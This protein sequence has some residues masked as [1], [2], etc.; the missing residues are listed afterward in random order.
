M[1][2]EDNGKNIHYNF[3]HW[4]KKSS[5]IYFLVRVEFEDIKNLISVAIFEGSFP[6]RTFFIILGSLIKMFVLAIPYRNAQYISLI[7][8]KKVIKI[9][10]LSNLGT[11][12]HVKYMYLALK[13]Y[14][15]LSSKIIEIPWHDFENWIY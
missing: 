14:N 2:I 13:K 7:P 10:F 6:Q 5:K 3:L 8:L 9:S 15:S 12:K 1:L 4:Q 11:T